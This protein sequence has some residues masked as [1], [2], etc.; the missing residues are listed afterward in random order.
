MSSSCRPDD[1]MHHIADFIGDQRCNITGFHL[2]TFNQL[3]ADVEVTYVIEGQA[4]SAK[5]T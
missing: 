1:L 5:L 4:Q 2:Y 3:D